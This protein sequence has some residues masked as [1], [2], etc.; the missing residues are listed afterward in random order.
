M[1]T[2]LRWASFESKGVHVSLF[3][4]FYEPKLETSQKHWSVSWTDASESL[5]YELHRCVRII[6]LRVVLMRQNHWSVSRQNHWSVSCNDVSE[7][8]VCE[9]YR[10]VR[11]VGLKVVR[12]I[13]LWVV[14]KASES[15]VCE[16][17]ESLFQISDN[18]VR[19]IGLARTN[20]SDKASQ[21]VLGPPP[22]LTNLCG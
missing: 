9:L 7:S 13:G 4:K 12:I 22:I 20:D 19:I 17:S 16:S 15:L 5:V 1:Q 18:P 10:C 11:I 6:G 14:K 3:R 8:L 21:E 2:S